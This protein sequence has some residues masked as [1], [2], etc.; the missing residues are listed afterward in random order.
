MPNK[1]P[2]KPKPKP[3]TTVNNMLNTF[4]IINKAV[5]DLQNCLNKNCKYE[6]EN[7]MKNEYSIRAM[8]LSQELLNNKISMAVFLKEEKELN[9]KILKCKENK[10]LIK[11]QLNKCYDE[12][13]HGLNISIDKLLE[14]SPKD[15]MGYKFAIEYNKNI[16]NK[17]LTEKMIKYIHIKMKAVN[18]ENLKI[19]QD[20]KTNN[21]KK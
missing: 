2:A 18:E 5:Q 10:A 9:K 14:F 12:T 16:R 3:K 21:Q 4:L 19:L 15:S 6:K 13:T 17:K 11:C 1:E 8:N 20:I 7:M